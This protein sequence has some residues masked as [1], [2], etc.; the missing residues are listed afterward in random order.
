MVNPAISLIIPAAGQGRRMDSDTPKP[1]MLLADKIVLEHTL[2]CFLGMDSL[3]QVIVSTTGEFRNSTEKLLE[4]LFPDIETQTVSGGKRRQDSIRNAL[5]KV[6][7]SVNL[8]AVHDAVR[9]FVNKETIQRCAAAAVKY[10]AA[11]TGV[12]VK[13]TIKQIDG[14][15]FIKKTPDRSLLWQAQTPQ[16]FKHSLLLKAYESAEKEHYIGT[17]DASLVEATGATVK[18]VEGQRSNIKL[19]Y[20]LD[21]TVAEMLVSKIK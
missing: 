16:I 14:N 4:K 1:Y 7:G 17:D 21:F 11:I 9:P 10:G 20:P 6:A 2:S 5:A 19:T 8:I 15:F 12:P 13:D 3:V 18:M